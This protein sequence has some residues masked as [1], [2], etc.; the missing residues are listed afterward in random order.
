MFLLSNDNEFNSIECQVIAA[1][2]QVVLMKSIS[3]PHSSVAHEKDLILWTGDSSSQIDAEDKNNTELEMC[4][5]LT[6]KIELNKEQVFGKNLE[7]SGAH[8]FNKCCCYFG[9]G[10]G[11]CWSYTRKSNR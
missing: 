10:N 4:L 2:F 5:S 3:I 6:F 9:T 7:N 8:E 1:E 11:R